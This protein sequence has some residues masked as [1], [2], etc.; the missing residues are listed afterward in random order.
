LFYF[1]DYN[2]YFRDLEHIC[3]MNEASIGKYKVP[4]SDKDEWIKQLIVV[5]HESS[6]TCM[7]FYILGIS[8]AHSLDAFCHD[9]CSLHL[10]EKQI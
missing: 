4:N 10:K 1:Q 2:E 8:V 9:V 3:V 7:W 5:I 6:Y